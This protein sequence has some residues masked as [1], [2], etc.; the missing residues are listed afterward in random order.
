MSADTDTV[1]S[2][3]NE[4]WYFSWDV[5]DM[6]SLVM[7]SHRQMRSLWTCWPASGLEDATPRAA[8]WSSCRADAAK[9]WTPLMGFCQPR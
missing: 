9:P 1:S 4:G 5:D 8:W 2:D 6:C 3:I 7:H